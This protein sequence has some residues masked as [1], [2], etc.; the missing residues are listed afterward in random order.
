MN[1]RDHIDAAINQ[2][3]IGG[4]GQLAIALALVAIAKAIE[5]AGVEIAMAIERTGQ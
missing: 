5:E 1:S 2:T 3:K 4:D